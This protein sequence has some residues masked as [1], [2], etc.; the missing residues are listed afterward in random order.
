[1][2]EVS[3]QFYRDI[4]NPENFGVVIVSVEEWGET[5]LSL[6]TDEALK[7]ADDLKETVTR[8]KEEGV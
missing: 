8:I 1:V 3:C 6:T 5:R 2:A 4:D 7:L